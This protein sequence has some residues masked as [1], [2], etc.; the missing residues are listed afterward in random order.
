MT[1]QD[2]PLKEET[3]VVAAAY[4]LQKHQVDHEQYKHQPRTGQLGAQDRESLPEGAVSSS[5][6][7]CRLQQRA[8]D[9]TS[10]YQ[11]EPGKVA[12][13]GTGRDADISNHGA[14]VT[15]NNNAPQPEGGN[16]QHV[17]MATRIDVLI[18]PANAR[19]RA[20]MKMPSLN[21]MLHHIDHH[22]VS[23]WERRPKRKPPPGRIV[24][25]GNGRWWSLRYTG[26]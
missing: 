13:F 1:D 12:R 11:R 21:P 14:C 7:K 6:G 24:T 16:I 15:V 18:T 23:K 10:G 2:D 8:N 9:S 19:I 20:H 25:S 3:V 26:H 5:V 22:E 4:L 17:L